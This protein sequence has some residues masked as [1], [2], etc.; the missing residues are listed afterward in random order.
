M[1][2]SITFSTPAGQ[3]VAEIPTFK[4]NLYLVGCGYHKCTPNYTF[5]HGGILSEY[6]LHFII[7]GK[8]TITIDNNTHFASKNDIFI[9]PKNKSVEY[10]ADSIE[11]WEYVWVKF[12]GDFAATY[13]ESV[14]LSAAT[15]VI[16]SIVDNM[17]YVSYIDSMVLSF[18]HHL[19]SDLKRISLL[20]ELLSTLI[21]NQ[22]TPDKA[23]LQS[24]TYNTDIDLS[25]ISST[26]DIYIEEALRYIEKNYATTSVSDIASYLGINR[27]YFCTLFKKHLNT[28]PKQYILNHTMEKAKELLET[29]NMSI[30]EIS[31]FCGYSDYFIFAKTYKKFY[32]VTPSSSRRLNSIY[33]P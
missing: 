19:S 6:H 10:F 28:S 20:F 21:D 18:K 11:P 33:L 22:I 25:A 5:N 30:N 15:P 29:T 8:G 9:L 16:H 23:L 27:S 1:K 3:I 2:K 32:G 24:K 26:C 12:A 31:T 7:N 13:L 4:N 17:F 14:G